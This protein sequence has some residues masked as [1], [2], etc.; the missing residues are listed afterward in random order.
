LLTAER[1]GKAVKAIASA[2]LSR[3]YSASEAFLIRNIWLINAR[4]S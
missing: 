4:L 3:V 1:Q 2:A